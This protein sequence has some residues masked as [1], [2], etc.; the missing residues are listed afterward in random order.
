VEFRT[1]DL[2]ITLLPSVEAQGVKGATCLGNSRY[3]LAPTGVCPHGTMQPC[4]LYSRCGLTP[5]CQA[6]TYIGCQGQTYI[7]CW[8]LSPMPCD[9]SRDPLVIQSR[10]DIRAVREELQADLKRLEELEKSGLPA[11][12]ESAEAAAELETKLEAAL[13]EIRQQKAKLS[14]K[15]G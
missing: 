9:V 11:Q 2:M 8:G 4:G 13:T 7:G 6:Q 1:K 3:C 10:E 15:R 5:Y 12:L 14:S